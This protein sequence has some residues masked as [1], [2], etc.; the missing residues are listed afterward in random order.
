MSWIVSGSRSSTAS[1]CCA[2]VFDPPREELLHV[3]GI[4]ATELFLFDS[5]E[6]G[7]WDVKSLVR[8][9]PVHEVDVVCALLRLKSGHHIEL[10]EQPQ[11]AAANEVR[12]DELREMFRDIDAAAAVEESI[13]KALS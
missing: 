2:E 7:K 3:P 9:S 1:G 5:I 8:L 12:K 10:R 11:E 4:A 6:Q 13:D